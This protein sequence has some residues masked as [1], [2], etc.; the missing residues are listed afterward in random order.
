[1]QLFGSNKKGKH[2]SSQANEQDEN[3]ILIDSTEDEDIAGLPLEPETESTPTDRPPKKSL[4]ALWITLAAIAGVVL[5]AILVWK[6]VIVKAPEVSDD[7]PTITSGTDITE[8]P[9]ENA[10]QTGTGRRDDVYTFMIVGLDRVGNNTDTIMVGCFDTAVGELNIVNIPRD[11]LINSAYNV[12]KINYLY[13]AAVNNNKD[14]VEALMLGVKN[15]L[16]FSVDNYAVI[17][18]E[19]CAKI[20]DVIG[21]VTFD[22]PCNMYYDDPLQNLHIA[23]S[24]GTQVLNGDNFVKVMRFRDTYAGGDIQRI[25]VQQ[26]LLKALAK[27]TLTAGNIK[28]IDQLLKI[29]E[30]YVDTDLTANN[31][32]FFLDEFLKTSIDKVTFSTVPNDPYMIYSVSY[33]AIRIDEWISMVNEKLNPYA[34]PITAANIDVVSYNGR[35]F[36]ATTGV[37]SGGSNS[38]MNYNSSVAPNVYQYYEKENMNADTP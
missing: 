25:G 27:Q 6:L 32:A 37:L 28:N 18:I 29:Y 7:G 15:L 22:V 10:P 13:P 11:T 1:M 35:D 2:T 3:D 33:V 38:F 31:V 23:I 24:A 5:A 21:G 30:E 34:S 26:D 4:K 8:Q 20:V 14:G 12:K 36:T 17:D 19:A 9:D 16:G